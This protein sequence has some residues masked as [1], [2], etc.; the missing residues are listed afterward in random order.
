MI[1]HCNGVPVTIRKHP[2]DTPTATP[3]ATANL[4]PQALIAPP[5]AL[6][7][8]KA[9]AIRGG[10]AMVVAN[11]IAAANAYTTI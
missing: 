8:F 10:S 9:T 11:P 2:K 3:T 4:S 1:Y 6:S 5:D 7:A